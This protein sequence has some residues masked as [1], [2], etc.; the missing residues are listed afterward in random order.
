MVAMRTEPKHKPATTEAGT[1]EFKQDG[2]TFEFK[3]WRLRG[4]F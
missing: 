2:G 4:I 1:I 3:T